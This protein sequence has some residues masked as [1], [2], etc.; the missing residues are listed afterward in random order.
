MN[1]E[2]SDK[3]VMVSTSDINSIYEFN[4]FQDQIQRSSIKNHISDIIKKD[5]HI[6]IP[7]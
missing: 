3:D 6:Q 5:C 1:K 4:S 7:D 2:K